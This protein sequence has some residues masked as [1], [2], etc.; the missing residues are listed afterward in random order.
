MKNLS[1]ILPDVA[2]VLDEI[3]RADDFKSSLYPL[4]LDT[5]VRL[6]A[7]GQ[8]CSYRTQKPLKV[9]TVLT[10]MT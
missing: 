5:K 9:V 2:T 8:K 6:K 1:V 10:K 3:G 7:T 4:W